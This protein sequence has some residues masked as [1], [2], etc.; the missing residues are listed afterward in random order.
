MTSYIK[1]VGALGSVNTQL[2][3]LGAYTALRTLAAMSSVAI[4]I[5]ASIQIPS[6]F[7]YQV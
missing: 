7:R 1:C 3:L 6:L 5:A 4:T 2:T